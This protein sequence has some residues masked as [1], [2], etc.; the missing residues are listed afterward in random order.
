[1][2]DKSLISWT[3]ATWPVV[4][5]CTRVSLACDHCYAIRDSWRMGHNPN[6]KIRTVY[7]GTVEP[8]PIGSQVDRSLDWSG[9]VRP[10]PQRLDWPL[11]WRKPRRI[12]V[13]NMSDLFHTALPFS[14]VAAVFGIMAATP[15]HTHQV[16][17]KRAV[18]LVDW[19]QVLD[20]R[21]EIARE[22]FPDDSLNWR[23]R[24]V[25]RAAAIYY[26]GRALPS[27]P[28]NPVWPL[29]NV[30]IGVTTE[31]QAMAD[32]RIGALLQVPAAVRFVSVEPMLGPV[33]LTAFLPYELFTCKRCGEEFSAGEADHNGHHAYCG[34]EPDP[35]G[36]TEG[37]DW[38]IAG[39][40][41]GP[42]RRPAELDWFRSLHGQCQAARVPFFLKQVDVGGKLEHSPELDGRQWREF[43]EVPHG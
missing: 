20:R 42:G 5:G 29:P 6:P 22:V 17:T 34:G 38:V 43:P 1:M 18:R 3:D 14:F 30:H 31:N 32:E 26:T 11:R 8:G 27:I 9:V 15:Q 4:A 40:E 39:S 36:H 21:A 12:F 19:F 2:A 16:L 35:Q 25:L 7:E 10:L 28:E 41:S 24:H 23:R 33:D 13:C 37:L